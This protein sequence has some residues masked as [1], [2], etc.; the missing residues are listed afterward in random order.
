MSA[1]D[2][3]EQKY[4]RWVRWLFFSP[5]IPLFLLLIAA[6]YFP[7]KHYLETNS[8]FCSQ[9]HKTQTEYM[10]W[11]QSSHKGIVC[12]K[13]HHETAKESLQVL[14]NYAYKSDKVQKKVHSP[15]VAIDACASCHFHHDPKWPQI[16]G[17]FAHKVHVV[18]HKIGC[19]DCHARSIH[20]FTATVDACIECHKPHKLLVSGMEA[21]HCFACHNFLNNEKT[22]LPS[23]RLCEDCHRSRGVMAP[24][25]PK[26][27]HMVKFPCWACHRPHE[28][29]KP[30]QVACRSCHDQI[31]RH[32]LHKVKQH[33][34]CIDCHQPHEWEPKQ[35]ECIKCHRDKVSHHAHK[36]CWECH[37]FK[38]ASRAS[39]R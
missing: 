9:C 25:F 27:A 8:A 16:G 12:Q 15:K 36:E 24:P 23:R 33:T 29:K 32:G 39:T 38:S 21:L 6:I 20:S 26:N 11:S 22:L 31:A 28:E 1:T 17:S 5:W 4:E 34:N 37:S 3:K 14:L 2:E 30:S 10:L 7:L 19:L 13:C 18:D 35:R